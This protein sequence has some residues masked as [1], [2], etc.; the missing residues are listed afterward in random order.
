MSRLV[1]PVL[2]NVS[3]L[4]FLDESP[5][6]FS[7]EIGFDSMKTCFSI[8]SKETFGPHLREIP[9]FEGIWV[10]AFD[11]AIP[12][13]YLNQRSTSLQIPDLRWKKSVYPGVGRLV[14]PPIRTVWMIETSVG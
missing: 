4:E 3:R 7:L 8:L 10:P 9:G 13:N 14:L 11:R 1:Y 12:R 6:F 2:D 5:L